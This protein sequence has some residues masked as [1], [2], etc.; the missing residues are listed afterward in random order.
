[1]IR[2]LKTFEMKCNTCGQKVIRIASHASDAV[3]ELGWSVIYGAGTVASHM[4]PDCQE[5]ND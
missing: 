5:K 2:E 4:C 3:G 1:M